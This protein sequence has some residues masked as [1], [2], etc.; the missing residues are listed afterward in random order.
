MKQP[1]IQLKLNSRYDS[2]RGSSPFHTHYGFTSRFGEA[3]MHHHL[4]MIVSDTDRHAEVT[5][6]LKLAKKSQSFQGNKRRNSPA[7][8]RIVQRVL[9]GSYYLMMELTIDRYW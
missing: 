6:N 8:L 3:R 1:E 5:N 2:S 7:R 4:N 9:R